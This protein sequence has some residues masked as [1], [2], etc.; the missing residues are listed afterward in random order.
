M[1]DGEIIIRLGGEGGEGVISAGD[2]FTA[3]A[4]RTGYHVYTFRTYPSEIKG[5]HAWYQVRVGPRPVYSMGDGVD[6]L[7][8]FDGEAYHNHHDQINPDGVLLYDAD[9]VQPESG[10]FHAYPVPFNQIAKKDLDF[11]RGKNLIVLGVLSSLFGL[12]PS[13]LEGLI[14]ARFARRAE[15]LTKNLESLHYGYKYAQENLTKADPHYLGQGDQVQ[16]FVMS[17]NDA[18]VAGALHAGCRFFA[19]YPITPASDIMESLAREMP[20][21]GGAFI[22]AEDEMAALGYVLG[23]SFAGVRAMTA[24]SGPG[25]SLMTEMLGLGSMAELPAVLVNAQRSGPSTGM[26][27][28]LEQSDLNHALYGGHGDFPRI[29]MAGTCV[30][31]CF[32]QII[33]A[34]NM[35][36]RFQMPV[37]FLS[38]QSLSHRTEAIE[39]PD[40]HRL[41]VIG[42][43]RVNGAGN[44]H[45]RRYELTDSGIVPMSVPGLDRGTYVAT[46]LEHDERGLPAIEAD[47]HE[48]MTRKRFAKFELARRELGPVARYGADRAEIGVIGWGSTEGPIREA[49]ERAVAAGVPVAALHPRVLKPLPAEELGT[50]LASVRHVIVP[51]H[52]F[53][54]QFGK[55]LRAELGVD[56]IPLH[57]YGGL[58]FTPSEI[59]TKILAVAGAGVLR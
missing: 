53:T 18:I 39:M 38:D 58:P 35:A 2:L 9:S 5:G 50:F 25:F 24:T 34:F 16:R 14:R 13:S 55:Y 48:N 54:G 22:Q 33:S 8:A 51:E 36:E 27:T 12:D 42:R 37:I 31:D 43:A 21:I 40:L 17:G 20:K 15:L 45:Y 11:F 44:G 4:A 56:S 28:K 1:A 7:V 29:V 47:N 3:G 32:Y 26:P 57:K 59:Y 49:V 6:V 52:N 30:E 19:G 10:N 41:P 23:A 46:G